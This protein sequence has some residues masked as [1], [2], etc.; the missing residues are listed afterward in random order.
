MSQEEKKNQI[1]LKQN[2][3]KRLEESALKKEAYIKNR[4]NEE[5]DPKIDLVSA[6]LKEESAKLDEVNNTI[7]QWTTKKN[8]LVAIVKN[9]EKKYDDLIKEKQSY[10]KRQL[11]DINNE[12]KTKIKALK[13]EIKKLEKELKALVAV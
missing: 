9:L 7:A 13:A 2:E 8:E 1:N 11:K 5:F 10:L 12:K 3:I 6:E 4:S